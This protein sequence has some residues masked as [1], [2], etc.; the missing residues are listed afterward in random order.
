MP[1]PYRPESGL[2]LPDI[3]KRP[4][5]VSAA[6]AFQ[7]SVPLLPE[8]FAV[9]ASPGPYVIEHLFFRDDTV[10]RQSGTEDHTADQ[11]RHPGM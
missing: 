4:V 11:A 5:A 9:K 2:N 10:D 8:R 6:F 7:M 3:D 1:P